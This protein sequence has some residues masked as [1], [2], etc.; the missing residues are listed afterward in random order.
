VASQRRGRRVLTLAAAAVLAFAGGTAGGLVGGRATDTPSAVG[1][2]TSAVQVAAANGLTTAEIA[3][4]VSPS[5]VSIFVSGAQDVEGSGVVL[6]ADGLILTNAHV[7]DSGGSIRVQFANG[8]TADATVVGTDASHDLAV[9]RARGVSGLTPAPLGASANVRVGDTVLAFGS[10]LGLEGTV[11]AGIVSAVNRT[12]DSSNLGQTNLIQ[13][14]AA[15]NAGSSGGPLVD[16]SGRVIGI[17]VAIAT[18]GQNS[19]NIGVGFAIP[20]DT[21]KTV[22]AQ[23]TGD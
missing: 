16:A 6:S 11:T 23:L 3:A 19:G 4:A 15:I 1:A 22:V 5:V 12:V 20:I 9:I 13:T 18:T 10:P 7:V 14:D 2:T 17:N 21:V 8:S